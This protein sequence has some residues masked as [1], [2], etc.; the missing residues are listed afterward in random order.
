M[1]A[2][3]SSLGKSMPALSQEQQ[4]ATAMEILGR[5]KIIKGKLQTF[6][7]ELEDEA[8]GPLYWE[9]VAPSRCDV[10]GMN[11]AAD[12]ASSSDFVFP[13]ALWFDGLEMAS[14]LTLYW[15]IQAMVPCPPSH[16]PTSPSKILCLPVH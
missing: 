7:A 5:L 9:R 6:Y 15:A 11:G 2:K 12:Q 16:F 14:M 4:L 3:P 1:G 10:V 8:T 13:P